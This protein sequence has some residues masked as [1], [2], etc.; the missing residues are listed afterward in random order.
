[1][2]ALKSL[3]YVFTVL[4]FLTLIF[5]LNAQILKPVEWTFEKKQTGPADFELHFIASIDPDW[6]IYSPYMK[7]GGP[8]PTNF[9][10]DKNKNFDLK[11]KII[12]AG[13]PK[14]AYEEVFDME[15]I[16]FENEA[17]FIQKVSLNGKK[18]AKVE[19]YL[20]FMTCDGTQCL[21][22][23]DIEFVFL[24]SY[25]ADLET[26]TSRKSSDQ[27]QGADNKSLP[28]FQSES[29]DQENGFKAEYGEIHD[30]VQWEISYKHIE[31]DRYE[32]TFNA[33]I[34]DGWYIYAP[35]IEEGGPIPTNFNFENKNS[36]NIISLEEL[37]EVIIAYDSIFDMSLR[38]F[39]NQ[40]DFK[41]TISLRQVVSQINGY[42]EYMAC[43]NNICLPPAEAAFTINVDES[44]L[45]YVKEHSENEKG[46]FEAGG[47]SDR[48]FW[49]MF[50]FGIIGGF[51]A[52]L[53]PCVFPM[54]ALTV[55][56]FTQ[57]SKSRRK[58]II[59]ASFY[60]FS[61]VII[62]VT[63]GF[64]LSIFYGPFAMTQLASSPIVNMIFFLIL[65]AFA[66]SFFGAF[67]LQMPSSWVNSAD[68]QSDRGGF[69]GIFFMALTLVLVSFACTGPIIGYLLVEAASGSSYMGPLA[70][71]TGFAIA[72]SIPFTLF[73]IFPSWLQSMPKSGGWLNT[74]KVSL[75]FII[76][77]ISLQFFSK[78]DQ[79]YNWG[80]LTRDVFLVLWIVI[81]T[82]LAFYV[83]GKIKFAHD[84]D[85]KHISIPR[86]FFAIV[87]F[88]L[89]A[90]LVPGLWGAPLKPL[91]GF[92]PPQYSHSWNASGGSAI[93]PADGIS[94]DRLH[95]DRL[96][97]PHNINC[98]FDFD[99]GLAYAREVDKPVM[100]DFTGHSCS[101]CRVM[102]A[103][104]WSDPNVLQ[105]LHNDY[106]V[107]ALYVDDR[108]RLDEA[109]RQSP[110]SDRKLRNLGQKWGDLQS[111]LFGINALPYYVLMDADGNILAQP[112]DYNTNIQAYIKFLDEGIE[113]YNNNDPI[114]TLQLDQYLVRK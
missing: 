55:S 10:F 88:S 39:K 67:E 40:A 113:R 89:A 108:T 77:A 13:K 61:I 54:V 71:M 79:V 6:Y 44:V 15:A 82:M 73:A 16:Y 87:F 93:E 98:F 95:S 33:I 70:G 47:G 92:L 1:M 34:E 36:V 29:L 43:D 68:K 62:F 63:I 110:Y 2:N 103:R 83:I 21:P 107:I 24:L 91:S 50:L 18:D 101:N 41:M 96:T 58:S 86:L 100:L 8:I 46:T 51:I 53:T 106:V 102:E 78:V 5:N 72:L 11:G 52:I 12:E 23:T 111:T 28:F 35:G 49:L 7:S 42:V 25:N 84:T 75:G 104:V 105:K 76:L 80:I 37:S 32:L 48:G 30:P 20:E 60:G 112:R 97:C 74:I 57:K 45:V 65:F 9:N 4:L 109:N 26:K 66:L 22:P 90:Y 56:F 59:D 27:K 19:G 69:I 85:V 64:L 38:Y 99:E 14:V 94:T 81:F 3:R 31:N 114:H 17:V